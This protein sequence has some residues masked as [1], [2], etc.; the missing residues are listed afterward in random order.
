MDKTPL[1]KLDA[2]LAIATAPGNGRDDPDT[3]YVADDYMRGMANGLILAEHIMRDRHGDPDYVPPPP[4][5]PL[6][7]SRQRHGRRFGEPRTMYD[8]RGPRPD[9]Y[10]GPLRSAGD[11]PPEA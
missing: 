1:D 3:G 2:V 7:D 4:L 6:G 8:W 11:P 9:W 5:P 10:T